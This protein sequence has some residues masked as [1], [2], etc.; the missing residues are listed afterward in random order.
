VKRTLPLLREGNATMQHPKLVVVQSEKP[1]LAS[2]CSVNG[3][4]LNRVAYHNLEIV[5]F[6]EC[7]SCEQG[8]SRLSPRIHRLEM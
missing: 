5:S 3:S 4:T 1:V 8:A 2:K 7:Q 6:R